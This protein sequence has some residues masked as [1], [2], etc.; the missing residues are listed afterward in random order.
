[1]EMRGTI[2]S[3]LARSALPSKGT[4][5]SK[6]PSEKRDDGA[7]A[8][9][10]TV[11]SESPATSGV[12]SAGGRCERD[13]RGDENERLKKIVE[14]QRAKIRSM[15]KQKDLE[16]AILEEFRLEAAEEAFTER[17][18]LFLK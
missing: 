9:R 1:M 6:P 13:D 3:F 18:V 12:R 8:R 10:T 4:G 15:E 17:R 5:K 7:V 14:S 16:E 11:R 2:P